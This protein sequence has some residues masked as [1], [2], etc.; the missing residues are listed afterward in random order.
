MDEAT[1][2][3][4]PEN[5]VLIQQAIS[6]LIKGKTVNVIVHRLRTDFRSK[7]ISDV[8]VAALTIATMF[9]PAFYAIRNYVLLYKKPSGRDTIS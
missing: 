8:S 7:R 1:A 4:E 9:L 3:L 5:E 2:S 6:R